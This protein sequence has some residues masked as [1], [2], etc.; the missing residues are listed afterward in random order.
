MSITNQANIQRATNLTSD[1]NF[2]DF[3]SLQLQ[4]DA[5]KLNICLVAITFID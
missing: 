3:S 5:P 4:N 2:V 1:G